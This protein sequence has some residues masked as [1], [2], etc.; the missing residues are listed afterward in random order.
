MGC[1]SSEEDIFV[2]SDEGQSRALVVSLDVEVCSAE[3]IAGASP[4]QGG[5]NLL[6]REQADQEVL[7]ILSHSKHGVLEGCTLG[8]L[9]EVHVEQIR[10]ALARV[11]FFEDQARPLIAIVVFACES[12]TSL[13]TQR[14]GAERLALA[15]ISSVD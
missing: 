1:V 8:L 10:S 12:I 7:L 15:D 2:A 3:T 14:H 9:P 4:K 13:V 11:A 6:A 5:L